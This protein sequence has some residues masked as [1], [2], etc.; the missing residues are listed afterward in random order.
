MTDIITQE[1]L[2]AILRHDPLAFVEKAFKTLHS[3]K[4]WRSSKHLEVITRAGEMVI[5]GEWSNLVLNAPPRSLKS[6]IISVA[7]VTWYLGHNPSREVMV[8]THNHNLARNLA[9]LTRRLMKSTFYMVLFPGTRLRDDFSPTEDIRTTAG[10][11]RFAL[12]IGS[13]VIGQGA[14]LLIID[15]PMNA[16]KA[17]ADKQREKVNTTYDESLQSRL[18]DKGSGK[19]IV[20]MQRLHA[21]DLCGHLQKAYSSFRTIALPL[22]A[23]QDIT[24]RIGDWVWDRPEGDILDPENWSREA[25]DETREALAEAVFEAQYQQNPPEGQGH[26][27]KETWFPLYEIVPKQCTRT[28]FSLD[29]AQTDSIGSSNS[30]CEVWQTDM[31]KHFLVD[32]WRGK[33]EYEDLLDVVLKYIKDYEPE[34]ILIENA[35]MGSSLISS[36]ERAGHRVK[37]IPKPKQSKLERLWAHLTTFKANGVLLPKNAQCLGPFLDELLSFPVGGSDDQVDAMTQYLAW[38]DNPDGLVLKPYTGSGRLVRAVNGR[39]S[40][41]G[42]KRRK[43]H[44]IRNPSKQPPRSF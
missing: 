4:K 15:D 22:I 35:A 8:I 1:N 43:P 28:I 13:G 2:N 12:S 3:G 31:V 18:N 26:Y 44:P 30:V 17:F 21:H 9:D 20:L 24:Y 40:S 39:Y 16:D 5:A 33:V 7:L 6:F 23:T 25:I 34:I 37:A 11:R 14:D 41:S 32:V 29:L 42:E 36:L 19:I 27:V 10:G 38:I